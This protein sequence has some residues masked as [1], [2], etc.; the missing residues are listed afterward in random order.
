MAISGPAG[1]HPAR[2]PAS[3]ALSRLRL[4]HRPESPVKPVLDGLPRKFR[5]RR[6]RPARHVR[7]QRHKQWPQ[8]PD[9]PPVGPRASD[10]D[11]R[12]PSAPG[13]AAAHLGPPPSISAP[14]CPGPQ[15]APDRQQQKGPPP[16]G[17]G[18]P[19]PCQTIAPPVTVPP[20]KCPRQGQ[21]RA[22]I[23]FRGSTLVAVAPA[24]PA[25][26]GQE[27]ACGDI[28]CNVFFFIAGISQ[29]LSLRS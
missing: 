29:N 25:R 28:R 19:C 14:G 8:R 2:P 20:G 13:S 16:D 4:A 7:R 3:I 12:S 1:H 21:T 11:T 27:S 23:R 26:Y 6:V 9:R 18:P 22:R 17:S 10:R 15:G 24:V 5:V